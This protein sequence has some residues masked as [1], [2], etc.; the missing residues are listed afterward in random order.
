M[1]FRDRVAINTALDE[2][3]TLLAR[4]GN[5]PDT[6]EARYIELRKIHAEAVLLLERTTGAFARSRQEA[7]HLPVIEWRGSHLDIRK[8]LT[9]F[10][11]RFREQLEHLVRES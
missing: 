1:H 4:L 9:P 3:G 7:I 5:L 11:H 10:L 8:A 2:T 6:G